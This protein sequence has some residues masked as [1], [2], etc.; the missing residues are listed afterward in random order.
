MFTEKTVSTIK[1]KLTSSPAVI[2][3]AP[4]GTGKTVG[5][6]PN[7]LEA[8]FLGG[9]KILVLEPRR[10]AAR[11]AA[12]F[13]SE[14]QGLPLGKE[15]GFRIRGDHRSGPGCRLEYI[16]EGI[17]TRM[18]LEDPALEHTGL[19][20]FDEF[21][22][23]SLAADTGLAMA[24]Y[25]QSLFRPD[26]RLLI[27]SA[28]LEGL[29]FAEGLPQAPRV[30]L[31]EAPH[32]VETLNI[33]PL[34][35]PL[36]P[37]M[38]RTVREEWNSP[39]RR[40]GKSSLLAFLPGRREIDEV[41]SL[42]GD[43]PAYPLYGDLPFQK[44]RELTQNPR[45]EARIILA[46]SLAE[47]SIT[48]PGVRTV[49]DSG[50][51]RLTRFHTPTGMSRLV[52][53]D[54]SRASADQRRGRA[55]RLGPGRC[56]RLW[57]ENRRLVD[58]EDPEILRG[59]L[60][61]LA[62][63]MAAWGADKGEMPWLTPPPPGPWE[64]AKGL[65][66]DLELLSPEGV[67][68]PLGQGSL[69]LGI[70]P[71]L[72]RM[73]LTAQKADP[74]GKKRIRH[75]AL[76]LAALLE[77]P[78]L[79]RRLTREEGPDLEAIIHRMEGQSMS[80]LPQP[81]PKSLG[82]LENR[83]RRQS[84]ETDNPISPASVGGLIALAYPDRILRRKKERPGTYILLS[85]REARAPGRPYASA[86]PWGDPPFLAAAE[87]DAG[88]RQSRI[89]SAAPLSE[90]EIQGIFPSAAQPRR[91]GIWDGKRLRFVTRRR[92]YAWVLEETPA[93]T[94]SPQ[95]IPKLL[96]EIIQEQGLD[97]LAWNKKSRRLLNRL[98]CLTM[99][100]PEEP[101]SPETLL[102]EGVSWLFP[103]I[104]SAS[105]SPSDIPLI[106]ALEYRL[107]RIKGPRGRELLR[108]RCPDTVQVPSGSWIPLNYEA[109]Q[110]PVLAVQIQEIFSWADTPPLGPESHP[111]P[112]TLH[113]LS[114]A[115]RPLQITRDLAGFWKTTWPQV[116]R[117]MAGRYP[118]HPWPEDPL[119]AP[120]ATRSGRRTDNPS[121]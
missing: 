3:T 109:P 5:L 23:R 79:L 120:P 9:K 36:L 72:A 2:L 61:P 43:L 10:I 28:T 114:P 66:R 34:D 65:L 55:G 104:P 63:T 111:L 11:N 20:I 21:H 77:E 92:L 71:R 95:E 84:G 101:F 117:E 97:I 115:G 26:L 31:G 1:E 99:D 4:P 40:R 14:I 45:G 106:P 94:P 53:E 76:L 116:R 110:N 39:R 22:E 54:V 17:L 121:H 105:T 38:A 67:I 57:P 78:G 98:R 27:M 56:L 24:L 19:I 15:I 30:T 8:P 60:A 37:L 70:H 107:T 83:L 119:S 58:Q 100:D 82:I 80:R 18:L 35:R 48:I 88:E 16:T 59:D 64:R 7:L 62:L 46:T 51:S 112:L 96:M 81:L 33:D 47:S 86:D 73:L 6:P 75:Q 85:G 69:R 102:R 93:S 113:L 44:Q 29:D 68:T 91:E 52:T 50:L 108:Q 42:L 12:Q 87:T 41:L 118:K 32:P 13:A 49:I 89:Y 90:E 74:R 103:F 25:C